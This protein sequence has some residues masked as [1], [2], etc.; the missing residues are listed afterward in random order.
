MKI[1]EKLIE[2]KMLRGVVSMPSNIFATTGTNVSILFLDKANTKG[3]IVLMDASKL[4]TIVKEGKN[5]KTLLSKEEETRIVETFIRHKAIKD[6]AVIVN[7][8]QIKRKSL[9]LSAGQYF[10][11]IDTSERLTDSEFRSRLKEF[12][13]K[14]SNLFL[15]HETIE[16][17]I[18]IIFDYW[19]LRF[20]FPNAEGRPYNSSG[21]QMVWN[22]I[23]GKEIPAGWQVKELGS[24]LSTILGGTPDTNNSS[25]W[26]DGDIAWISSGEIDSLPVTRTNKFITR[27]GLKNSPATLLPKGSIIISLVRYIRVSILGINASANQSVV[28]IM[29]NNKL[30]KNYL[31]PFVL[32]Q[33]PLLMKKRTG[34]QQPHINKQEI[35]KIPLIIPSDEILRK[36]YEISTPFFKALTNNKLSDSEF[37]SLRDILLPRLVKGKRIVGKSR[38]LVAFKLPKR[39]KR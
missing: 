37:F 26:K 34:A 21:G 14:L 5:Q 32:S 23:L 39:M 31:Y 27:K 4:G 19:F 29:E 13:R 8:D 12:R 20:N 15:L 33:V 7:Y 25:F 9:S 24:V 38:K 2:R 1:R 35:D 30:K 3:N 10:E 18:K 36:Y 22:E 16:E 28:G 17:I 6:F 11:V